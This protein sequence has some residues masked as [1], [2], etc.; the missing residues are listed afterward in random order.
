VEHEIDVE[1]MIIESDVLL[2][3]VRIATES[4]WLKGVGGAARSSQQ[5]PVPLDSSPQ[6]RAHHLIE[7]SNSLREK[8]GNG[9]VAELAVLDML[10][11]ESLA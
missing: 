8:Y 4:E 11:C 9:I 2:M 5:S 3:M 7:K 6:D 10:D 1:V